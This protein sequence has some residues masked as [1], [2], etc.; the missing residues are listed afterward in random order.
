MIT[1]RVSE[2]KPQ[3]THI[4]TQARDNLR[5]IPTENMTTSFGDKTKTFAMSKK[6]AMTTKKKIA[7]TKNNRNEKKI[8]AMTKKNRNARESIAM[9]Q[10]K[11]Q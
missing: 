3:K 9:T 1:T 11:S 2:I 5:N 6:I 10:Q 4:D 8:I 7:M